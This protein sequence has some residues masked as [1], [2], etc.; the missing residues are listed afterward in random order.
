MEVLLQKPLN[1]NVVPLWSGNHKLELWVTNLWAAETKPF[2]TRADR[3]TDFIPKMEQ[4]SSEA[5]LS[6]P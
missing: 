5:I 3:Q 1:N 4:I 6:I 2:S